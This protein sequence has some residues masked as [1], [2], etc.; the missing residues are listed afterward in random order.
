MFDHAPAD[1]A[2]S[3]RCGCVHASCVMRHAN[4]AHA[5]SLP[6]TRHQQSAEQ[7]LPITIRLAWLN[8][9]AWPSRL[10]SRRGPFR[11]AMELVA[12]PPADEP[13]LPSWLA[14]CACPG[15]WSEPSLRTRD[16]C[17]RSQGVTLRGYLIVPVHNFPA[18]RRP[19]VVILSHGFSATQHM[20]LIDTARAL[21][22]RT[23]CAALTFD[24]GGFGESDGKRHH[25]C[26]W[27][28]AVGYLDAVTYLR[29]AEAE[30]V[31]LDRICLWGESLSSRLALVAASVEPLVKAVILVT[32][33]CGR[34]IED[35]STEPGMVVRRESD[36]IAMAA[37][38]EEAHLTEAYAAP[39]LAGAPAG[40]E[41]ERARAQRDRLASDN[42]TTSDISTGSAEL[43]LNM[44]LMDTESVF[45]QMK[46]QLTSMRTRAARADDHSHGA[47]GGASIPP[48]AS[49]FTIRVRAVLCLAPNRMRGAAVR[50]RCAT[51]PCRRRL[52]ARRLCARAGDS[53]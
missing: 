42:S 5:L 49:T 28:Q 23:G 18:S 13:R 9:C 53:G 4:V 1:H 17:F 24:H 32:F 14:R 50:T 12:Q 6:V 41:V 35:W 19:P 25:F 39:A 43:E 38:A 37:L 15:S 27:T 11:K 2:C 51:D 45:N 30:N 34:R 48:V 3:S 8:L 52:C 44:R 47:T 21:C 31:D 26:L 29:Q 46:E 40:A 10:A 33:P 7:S 22:T 20:G 36:A 16:I